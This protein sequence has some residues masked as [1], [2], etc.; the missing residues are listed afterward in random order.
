MLSVL[1]SISDF[2]INYSLS[3]ASVL[4]SK[5][6]SEVIIVDDCSFLDNSM[7]IKQIA[8]SN[9][10]IKYYKNSKN[11]GEHLSLIKALEKSNSRYIIMLDSD[12]FIIPKAID[13]LFDYTHANKLD[14]AYGKMAIKKNNEI[15]RFQHPGYKDSSYIDSRNE[16]NDLFFY[17]NY[18]PRIGTI[19][20]KS[21]IFPYFNNIYHKKLTNE[22]G[23]SFSSFDYDLFINL[24]KK[25]KKFGFLDEFVCVDCENNNEINPID[26]EKESLKSLEKI[27]LFNKHFKNKDPDE[28]MM[29]FVGNILEEKLNFKKKPVFDFKNK[30]LCKHFEDFQKIKKKKN[31][32]KDNKL[33][34][35]KSLDTIVGFQSGH[36]VSYCLLKN[37]KPII[38]EE[39]ERFS[40]VKEELGDGLKMFFDAKHQLH[41]NNIKYFTF[42][43]F[44][45]RQKKWGNSTSDSLSNSKMD[46]LLNK[47]KGQYLELSHHMTHAANAFFSSNFK[48]SLILTID[49]GGNE[50]EKTMTCATIYEGKNN[51]I[52]KVNVF[53]AGELNLAS[54]WNLVTKLFDLSIGFPK[55]NQAGTVMAMASMS[56]SGKYV[57]P[58]VELMTNKCFQKEYFELGIESIKLSDLKKN[59][60]VNKI[61]EIRKFS[62]QDKFDIASSL[63]KASEFVVK[64]T[65]EKFLRQ[66]KKL[67]I[68]GGCALNS[69]I[70]GKIQD[71][72]PQIE[73]IYVPPVPYDS[74]LAIGS[75]QYLWHQI[76]GNKRI[77][78]NDNFT[79][80]LGR[81][82]DENDI[83]QAL[84]KFEDFITYYKVDDEKVLEYLENQKIVSVFGGGSESGR[85]ALGNRS[86]IADPRNEKMKEIINE[87]VKHR[88]W[89]RPFAPSIL[90]ERVGNWF[91]KNVSSPYMTHVIKWKKDKK[92]L[93]PAVVH[94]D[95]S[96]RLQTVTKNDNFW[97]YN[98]IK[99]WENKTGVPIV[100]NTSFNDSEPIVESPEDAIKC[101]L[102]TNID[103][104][105]FFD[106]QILVC[107]KS[108]N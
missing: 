36:D 83:K 12:D 8:E 1:T 11:L 24:A 45:G 41:Y 15:F 82:Y 96:A 51:Q 22:F 70:I 95:G 71:W 86:I 81:K 68:A 107:K 27:F 76:L 23:S 84:K 38:H 35:S 78:W 80:Y 65:L 2:S 105:Y 93:V 99:K 57:E 74:G 56:N 42:G 101:F 19:I 10:K 20:K 60:L 18:I 28:V 98:F 104:L 17:D 6:I 103:H 55:G 30:S 21:S 34:K 31:G 97:Y 9:C 63:Q 77:K 59:K 7:K 87:K 108:V 61:F 75:A 5:R 58:L 67:C 91:E 40:R 89:F 73:N 100:L 102:K 14:L 44:G 92:K 54:G 25:N 16:L 48:N 53:N 64:E 13:M 47:N 43:N 69:V 26:E 85:R 66:H 52:K 46:K 4:E 37:G 29:Y 49:G 3:M 62:E 32:L 39:L 79:P 94:Y 72:F 90:K 50:S 88:Q 33:K 106:Y